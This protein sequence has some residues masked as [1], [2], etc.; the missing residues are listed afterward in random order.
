M[1]APTVSSVLNRVEAEEGRRKEGDLK[2]RAQGKGVAAWDP[3]TGWPARPS[4]YS[5]EWRGPRSAG[6]PPEMRIGVDDWLSWEVR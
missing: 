6:R 4:F 5:V 1:S 3:A 2:I